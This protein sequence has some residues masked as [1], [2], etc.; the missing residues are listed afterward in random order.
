MEARRLPGFGAMVIAWAGALAAQQPIRLE[1]VKTIRAEGGIVHAAAFGVALTPDGSAVAVQ[2]RDWVLHVLDERPPRV[3]PRAREVSPGWRGPQLLVE[4]MTEISLL[5]TQ[6]GNELQRLSRGPYDQAPSRIGPAGL[7]CIGG[8]L[9]DAKGG[10][11]APL[12][13]EVRL[14]SSCEVAVAGDGRWAIGGRWGPHGDVGC[15]LVTDAN[16]KNQRLVD[17]G[18]VSSVTFSPD[19]K[20]L[21]YVRSRSVSLAHPYDGELV[22]VDAVTLAPHKKVDAGI[23]Q[24]RFLDGQRALVLA[25]GELQVWDVETLRPVQ[26][27]PVSGQWFQLADTCRTLVVRQE[28]QVQVYRVLLD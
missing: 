26:K 5:D 2:G 9:R 11:V 27:L 25:S 23:G 20:L 14:F 13:D 19:G 24:W 22:L 4:R 21:G 15:L 6:T 28:G 16:G 10:V 1:L 12:R 7:M 18:P 8:T 17:K 3:L